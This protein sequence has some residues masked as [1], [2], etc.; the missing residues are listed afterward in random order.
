MVTDEW[1]P[2]NGLLSPTL[3]LRRT[4][5]MEKYKGL[6]AEIYGHEKPASSGFFSAFKSVELPSIPWGKK[7]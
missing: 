7:D 5:L 3:K 2:A 1:T 6:I 4:P